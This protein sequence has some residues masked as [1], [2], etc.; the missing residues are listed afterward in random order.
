MR[1]F[2]MQM[3]MPN[4]TSKN[5]KVLYLRLNAPMYLCYFFMLFYLFYYFFV[6]KLI[7]MLKPIVKKGSNNYFLEV[8][9]FCIIF[10]L[11]LKIN[12]AI[13]YSNC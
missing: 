6:E 7:K 1:L 4:L 11:M 5:D 12:R 10:H 8:E 13:E 3:Q 2:V 9:N